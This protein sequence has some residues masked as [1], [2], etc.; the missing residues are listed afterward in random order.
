M[1]NPHTIRDILPVDIIVG[2]SGYGLPLTNINDITERELSLMIPLDESVPVNEGI[3][4]V[5]E[6]MKSEG[7]LVY[8]TPGVIHL[9]T[10]PFYRKAN[11]MDMGTADKVCS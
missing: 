1:T 11:R 9:P 10:V 5:I 6:L 3:R 4:R 7:L 8:F 2:P